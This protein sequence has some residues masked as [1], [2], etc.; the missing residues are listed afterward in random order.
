MNSTNDARDADVNPEPGRG[1]GDSLDQPDEVIE[2]EYTAGDYPA[3]DE[4]EETD[5]PT[6]GGYTAGDYPEGDRR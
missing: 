1:E 4:R 2:G 5:T 3:G 6:E